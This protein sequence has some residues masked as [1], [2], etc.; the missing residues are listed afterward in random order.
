MRP[1]DFLLFC[2]LNGLVVWEG[3]LT[4]KDKLF[5]PSQMEADGHPYGLPWIAHGGASWGDFILVT[6]VTV[7]MFYCYSNQWSFYEHW[8]YMLITTIVTLGFHLL[9]AYLNKLPDCLAWAGR[10]TR[11]GWVH[12]VYMSATLAIVVLFYFHTTNIN[13]T[14]LILVSVIIGLHIAIGNHMLLSLWAPPW[15][16]INTLKDPGALI[17]TVGVWTALFF[18]CRYILMQQ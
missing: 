1:I 4:Y 8:K 13:P 2:F 15:W 3:F 7:V 10:V 17:V 12:F 11:A 9:W 18:R 16:P 6:P 5:S 14:F